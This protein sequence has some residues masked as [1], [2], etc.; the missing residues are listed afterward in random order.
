MKRTWVFL[1]RPCVFFVL[2]Q[3]LSDSYGIDVLDLLSNEDHKVIVP[4]AESLKSMFLSL[5]TP[6]TTT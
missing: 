1:R 5:G 3:T 6:V 2:E 4:L